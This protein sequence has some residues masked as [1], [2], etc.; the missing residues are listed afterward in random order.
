MKY[1]LV[2]Q[3][4]TDESSDFDALIELEGILILNIGSDHNVDGHDFGSGEMNIF[5]HTDDPQEA[6]SSSYGLVPS[7]LRATLRAA[8]RRLDGEKYSWLFPESHSAEFKVV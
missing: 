3:F 1:Q 2:L 7:D 6:F 4:P 5:V 8:Y